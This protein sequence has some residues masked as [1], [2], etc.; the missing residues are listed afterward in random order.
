MAGYVDGFVMPLP[1]ANVERYRE[2]ATRRVSS[3]RSTAR[4][5]TWSASP[6]T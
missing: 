5:P 2:I 3:G 4:S 6:M 1:K